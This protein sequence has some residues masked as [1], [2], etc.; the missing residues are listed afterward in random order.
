MLLEAKTS[1]ILLLFGVSIF[2]YTMSTNVG[3]APATALRTTEVTEN[4]KA[5]SNLQG[6]TFNLPKFLN[7]SLNC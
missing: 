7:V 4:G 3:L 2:S 1:V 5:L 6:W